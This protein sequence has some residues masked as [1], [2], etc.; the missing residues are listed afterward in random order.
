MVLFPNQI[1]VEHSVSK[2]W[3]PRSKSRSVVSV[4]GLHSLSMTNQRT[5]GLHSLISNFPHT[6]YL[7]AGYF[8]MLLLP[9]LLTFNLSKY[10]SRNTIGVSNGLELDKDRALASQLYL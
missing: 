5:L 1:L 3:R 8:F 9:G 6:S 7:H 4:L 2:Q 10:Y